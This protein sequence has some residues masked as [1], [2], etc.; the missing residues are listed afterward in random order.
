MNSCMKPRLG[1]A[2]LLALAGMTHNA[3]ADSD[4]Q[5]FQQMA[6][7]VNGPFTS[8][9][10]INSF[11]TPVGTDSNGPPFDTYSS[12]FTVEFHGCA[13][14]T[15]ADFSFP[16]GVFHFSA[17]PIPEPETHALM[18]LGLGAVGWAARRRSTLSFS[19]SPKGRGSKPRC[20]NAG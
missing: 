17:G 6:A 14:F 10:T 1:A 11:G 19:F 4:A 2:V 20:I 18:L 9:F 8:I 3:W 12:I 15:L 13:C 7:G 5:S 16:G